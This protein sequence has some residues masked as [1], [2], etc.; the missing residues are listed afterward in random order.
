MDLSSDFEDFFRSASGLAPFP[1]QVRFATADPLPDLLTVP[2]GAGKTACAV[3]GWLWRR[4]QAPGA[5]RA[6]TPRRLVFCLPM[7]SLVEQTVEAARGWLGALGIPGDEVGVHPLLGGEVDDSW[8]AHPEGDALIVGTQDQLLSRA[9]G[10]GYAMS[11]HRWPIHFALLNN[12]CLWVLDEVQLM[13]P[14]L[15]T[16]AQLHAFR[17]RSLTFGPSRSVWM[18]A[19]LDPRR[20]E[21]VDLRGTPLRSLGLGDDDRACPPLALRL[22]ARKTVLP[23]ETP[24]SAD[25]R[26][27]ARGL[28]R[29]VLAAH[30]EASPTLVVLNRVARA[31]AVYGALRRAA[32]EAPVRLVHSRFRPADRRAVQG[33]VLGRGFA[34]ILVATQAVEAG[35]DLSAR[36]VF[37]ELAPWSSLVQ[38]AGRCNRRGEHGPGEAAVR[39]IDLPADEAAPYAPLDLA[40]AR[41]RLASL[42]D[43]GPDALGDTSSDGGDAWP[44]P[45]VLR[46]RDLL[47]LF[48][49]QPDLAGHDLDVSRFVRDAAGSDVQ[50]A[51]R[52]VDADAGPD[53][54]DPRPH[55]DELCSVPI[56]QLR[57][58]LGRGKVAAWR[59]SGLTGEWEKA[60]DLVPGM[61]VVLPLSAGGYA[62]DLGF[63]GDAKDRPG[64]VVRAAPPPGDDEADPLT[65]GCARFVPLAVHASDVA[66]EVDRLAEALP[67]DL[68]REA[69]RVAGRWHDLG[70]VHPAFQRML[71]SA[72]PEGDPLRDAGPFAKSDGRRGARNERRHFRHELAGALALLRH[73]GDDLAAYLVAAHH[74]KVRLA[75][76]S[77]PGEPP[78]PEGRRFALGIWE[79]DELPPADLGDG[80]ASEATT[81]SLDVMELGDRGD[82]RR[83]WLAR[84]LGLLEAWGPFRLAYLETLVRVADWRGTALRGRP[85]AGGSDGE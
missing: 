10:R 3:L 9:L 62:P 55:Q 12:D 50:V 1:Y 23:A 2:T 38:R 63:T 65:H 53:P 32:P 21:T 14:A 71:L 24:Y 13:G 33:E 27:Y 35:V 30:R 59:F 5:L 64:P 57:R 73:G 19:T 22:G 41:E 81:L 15:S 56:G 58:L 42:E 61:A 85:G 60:R 83:S 77:R 39:W 37:T 72:V 26:A 28:A 18:S 68:P 82:G 36:T 31:Q 79:G 29:E 49:T 43:A 25:A 8:E 16:T 20:L 80:V 4:R 66:A 75:L 7:R 78:A 69:L 45:P 70:K 17:A 76:R 84:S 6:S 74:G 44:A 34:G 11:R 46:R 51:W 67:P 54:G 52:D 47:E 40:A 48:D